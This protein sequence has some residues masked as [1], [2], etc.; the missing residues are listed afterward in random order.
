MSPSQ[1][2]PPQTS[3]QGESSGT[4]TGASSSPVQRPPGSS[5]PANATTQPTPRLGST[6]TR[7]TTIVRFAEVAAHT[8]KCDECDKRNRDG[9]SRCLT[10]GW[11]CC[12]KCLNAR[13]GDR[14]HRSFTSIH[15]PENER[16]N[17]TRHS[18]PAAEG[19]RPSTSRQEAAETLV[20][21][22]GQTTPTMRGG[23]VR[24]PSGEQSSRRTG[25]PAT[26]VGRQGRVERAGSEGLALTTDDDETLTWLSGSED[27]NGEAPDA[28]LEDTIPAR[29]N[30]PRAS[31]PSD[32]AE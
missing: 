23:N 28:S 32:M 26:T 6:R 27:G 14:T 19:S 30:P 7:E 15:A 13:G 11:Q 12:R 17:T 18:V 22:S 10:C 1:R 25:T 5:P 21:I 3:Q 2:A 4:N 29:R 16:R 31:R 9:M 20:G 8:A 24:L